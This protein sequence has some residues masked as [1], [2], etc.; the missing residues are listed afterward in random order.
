[1]LL[2]QWVVNSSSLPLR[3]IN[4]S[5]EDSLEKGCSIFVISEPYYYFKNKMVEFWITLIT[6]V[7]LVL[8]ATVL[9]IPGNVLSATVFYRQGLRERINLCL[10]GAVWASQFLSAVIAS[11]RCFCVVSPFHA[12]RLLK[13]STMAAIIVVCSV[14]LIGG[15]MT[16]LV[17]KFTIGCWFDPET[18]LTE[19]GTIASRR[20]EY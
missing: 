18:N 19:R 17:S 15:M 12:K 2:E 4:T 10:A 16:V 1:M 13:T 11:E 8:V 3:H 20:V 9:G 7:G 14:I 5:S 6:F